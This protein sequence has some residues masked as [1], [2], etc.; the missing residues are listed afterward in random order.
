LNDGN[1]FGNEELLSNIPRKFNVRCISPE[2]TLYQITRTD[3]MNTIYSNEFNKI[4]FN[5]YTQKINLYINKRLNL[6]SQKKQKD[7]FTKN[8]KQETFSFY[9]DNNNNTEIECDS[10]EIKLFF[11]D[12][13]LKIKDKNT[14]K[15]YTQ[16]NNV[17]L[18]KSMPKL[19]EYSLKENKNLLKKNLMTK[20]KM[21]KKKESSFIS[22]MILQEVKSLQKKNEKKEE[23]RECSAK[24]NDDFV[25]KR[26]FSLGKPEK[27]YYFQSFFLRKGV[28]SSKSKENFLKSGSK[29]SEISNL[30][31]TSSKSF[32]KI[33]DCD[34]M[35]V[36]KKQ[37]HKLLKQK[38]FPKKKTEN[39]DESYGLND[40]LPLKYSTNAIIESRKSQ[41][42]NKIK[43]IL[44]N[45]L[46][47][48]NIS[49]N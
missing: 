6:F 39:I 20:L 9:H 4:F 3:F 1:F 42:Q 24:K 17:D 37:L 32:F 26:H 16:R 35:K 34:K 36:L 11:S 30:F 29:E 18:L 12:E 25:V 13:I 19:Y 23:N 22:Q 27:D 47:K 40:Y 14:K 7:L 28:N 49:I 44:S 15:L 31:V 48:R 8:K 41:K 2:G 43:R 10:D 33:D 21:Q 45:S 46:I 38:E 5:E